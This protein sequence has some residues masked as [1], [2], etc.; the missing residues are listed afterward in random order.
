[1]NKFKFVCYWES[2]V[3][4]PVPFHI[5]ICLAFLKMKAGEDFVLLTKNNIFNFIDRE[6]VEKKI[7]S[8]GAIEADDFRQNRASIVAKSD[9]IRLEYI[10]NHGGFWVDSDGLCVG[11][12]YDVLDLL[13]LHDM[14]WGYEAFFGAKPG[15]KPFKIAAD[16]MIELPCQ[17]WGNP[18]RVKELLASPEYDQTFKLMPYHLIEPKKIFGYDWTNA[19]EVLSSN[20]KSKD[21]LDERQ[22]F[23]HLYNK[24]TYDGLLTSLDSTTE[25]NNSLFKDILVNNTDIDILIHQMREI[26]DSLQ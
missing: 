5:L 4:S 19:K 9:F 20:I 26:A 6:P 14:V 13:N 23:L 18:G 25:I 7:W 10:Y 22:V 16:N 17:I 11:N 24:V 8:F 12:C 3:N 15:Y 2:P 1:M 21:F